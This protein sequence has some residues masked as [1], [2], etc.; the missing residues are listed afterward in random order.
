MRRHR[1]APARWTAT[2]RSPRTA[3]AVA[4]AAGGC[5][6][7]TACGGS[8]HPSQH[9]ATAATVTTRTSTAAHT[10][11]THDVLEELVAKTRSGIVRIEAESCTEQDT[12][13]G[14]LISPH[15]VATVDHVVSGASTIRLIQH[16]KTA[17]HGTV[18]GEDAARDVALVRSSK[19]LSGHLFTFAAGHPALGESV[20]ALGFPFGLPLSVSEGAVSGTRRTIPIDG[21]QRHQLIQ[22]DAAVNPG[23][24]GG[25]LLSLDTGEVVGLV[26]IGTTQANGI[27]FAVSGAVAHPL[28][29]A[30]KAAPQAAAIPDCPT[31]ETAAA[32]P[33][34]AATRPASEGPL[35]SV[36][37]YW[38]DIAD[39]DYAAAWTHLVPTI[40]S[41]AE[42]IRGE[43]QAQISDVEF[44]GTLAGISGSY[45]TVDVVLLVTRDAQYGCRRWSGS[46]AMVKQGGRWLIEH[47]RIT[48]TAC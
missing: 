10:T 7:L 39:G 47:A 29:D 25:P 19:P 2:S 14:F 40:T 23:N 3:F 33:S 38:S 37:A 30:W 15:L 28:L 36:N 43:Q 26:D 18:I 13:T 45:A 22:T 46:Y 27:A 12:G 44:D 17:G 6:V 48:P 41:Q 20:A 5:V 21:V 42:F 24:S 11:T 34:A 32:P 9:T 8:S 4:V 16:G 35:S 1:F 31:D